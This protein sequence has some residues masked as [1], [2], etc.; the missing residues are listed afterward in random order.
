M[1]PDSE[2]Q[3]ETDDLIGLAVSHYQV[4]GRLGRGGMGAVYRAEDTRLP[5][6]GRAQVRRDGA[7]SR[8]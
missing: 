6:A 5:S 4:V 1:D 8:S 7:G 2:T 3:A